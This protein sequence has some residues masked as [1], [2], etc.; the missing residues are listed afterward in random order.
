MEPPYHGRRI[1]QID[2]DERPAGFV[3]GAFSIRPARLSPMLDRPSGGITASRWPASNRSSGRSTTRRAYL[4]DRAGP[5]GGKRR[6]MTSKP[7][8]RHQTILIHMHDDV[9]GRLCSVARRDAAWQRLIRGF[10]WPT[11]LP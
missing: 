5:A 7:A 10:E 9:P 4:P 3:P 1:G 8:G 6:R 2:S 11:S